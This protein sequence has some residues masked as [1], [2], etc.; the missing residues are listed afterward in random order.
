MIEY[1]DWK[2]TCDGCGRSETHPAH[3]GITGWFTIKVVPRFMTG[4]PHEYNLCPS[5]AIKAKEVSER[6]H[7]FA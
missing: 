3:H 7:P 4:G 1:G 2:W 6:K 5:C